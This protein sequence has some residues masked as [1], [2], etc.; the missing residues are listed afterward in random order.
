MTF[1]LEPDRPI[2]NS[3][4]R[5]ILSNRVDGFVVSHTNWDDP[6]I[7][8]L[9]DSDVPFVAFGRANAEFEFAY[10]DVDG[11]DGM[12][13]V[14]EHLLELGHTR[15]AY[16]GWPP[17]SVS[18]DARYSGYREALQDAGIDVREASE[19]RICNCVDEGYTAAAE[20]M[21]LSPAPTAIVCVSDVNAVGAMRYLTEH[22]YRVGVDVVVSGFDDIALSEFLSPP[23][24]TV[25]QPLEVIGEQL[26]QMLLTHINKK[27]V[28]AREQQ[29]VLKPQLIVRESTV[30][31]AT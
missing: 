31:K 28:P 14:T 18:G 30:P 27:G 1:V 21:T 5:L 26:I 3:Y 19:R 11:Y 10:V 12:R 25:H 17:E 9:M 24:T 7:E 22:G 20:L 2:V 16:I 29:V 23:L 4:Q 15:F 8:M 13:Q 6:R